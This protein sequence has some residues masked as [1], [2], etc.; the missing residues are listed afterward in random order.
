MSKL[1]KANR[2]S[3]QLNVDVK[4]KTYVLNSFVFY[5]KDGI[6]FKTNKGWL[7]NDFEPNFN[8]EIVKKLKENFT[9]KEAYVL[10]SKEL[11][12]S[13]SSYDLYIHEDL[14]GLKK[15]E[16]RIVRNTVYAK[17]NSDIEDFNFDI[18]VKSLE[19]NLYNI[20]REIN[21]LGKELE[22]YMINYNELEFTMVKLVD[23]KEQLKKEEERLSKYTIEDYLNSVQ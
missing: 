11:S 17:Y 2:Y 23:L 12:L 22:D 21:K 19:D 15:P 3:V 8:F 14:V 9:K 4:G 16:Y 7:D 18:Y 20:R 13:D 10:K 6:M 5:N 1:Y